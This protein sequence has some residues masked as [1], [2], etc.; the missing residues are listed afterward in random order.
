M[1]SLLSFSQRGYRAEVPFFTRLYSLWIERIHLR[2]CSYPLIR[3]FEK[4]RW[5]ANGVLGVHGKMDNRCSCSPK[6]ASLSTLGRIAYLF[7][8][9]AAM[10][11]F[12]TRERPFIP[13]VLAPVTG[14]AIA[15]FEVL[16]C[17]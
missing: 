1:Q 3:D 14:L 12:P 7:R 4:F 6:Y 15:C 17:P 10:E 11:Q 16:I 5:E 8:Y 9:W 13:N 2:S